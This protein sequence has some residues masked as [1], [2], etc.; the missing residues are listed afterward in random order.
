M[1]HPGL[2]IRVLGQ[3][4]IKSMLH[5]MLHNRY[6]LDQTMK[7]SVTTP[8]DSAMPSRYIILYYNILYYNKY[9]IMIN[10]IL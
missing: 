2:C 4:L 3:D 5:N 9:Y 10:N 1:L 6:I 8:T 7:L